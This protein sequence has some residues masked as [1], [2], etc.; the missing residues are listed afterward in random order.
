M[1]P[2]KSD[3]VLLKDKRVHSSFKPT[4]THMGFL[5][6]MDYGFD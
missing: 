4:R 6:K 3:Y 2:A 1:Y 5:A